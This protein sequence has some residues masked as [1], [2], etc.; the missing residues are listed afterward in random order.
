VLDQRCVSANRQG[1]QLACLPFAKDVFI[2]HKA[3]AFNEDS[4]LFGKEFFATMLDVS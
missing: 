3:N 1:N 4:F 2:H